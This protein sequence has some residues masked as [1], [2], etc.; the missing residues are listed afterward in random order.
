[1]FLHPSLNSESA[2]FTIESGV[3]QGCELSPESSAMGSVGIDVRTGGQ[4]LNCL[5][6]CPWIEI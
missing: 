2:W 3:C 6:F 1:M 5:K 4:L